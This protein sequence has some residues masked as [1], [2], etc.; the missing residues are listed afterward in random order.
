MPCCILIALLVSPF[1]VLFRIR[2][3]SS[4]LLTCC[5]PRRWAF[6]FVAAIIASE[7]IAL[8]VITVYVAHLGAGSAADI[9][10]HICS[11]SFGH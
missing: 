9:F 10:H 2:A 1:A 8:V 3:R 5:G 4:T 7:L 6:P 11:V